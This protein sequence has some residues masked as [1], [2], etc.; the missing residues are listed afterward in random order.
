MYQ[1]PEKLITLATLWP[2]A[3]R[4]RTSTRS[5]SGSQ[6]TAVIMG[7]AVSIVRSLPAAVGI[8]T[9]RPARVA[10]ASSHPGRVPAA[11][12]NPDV[13]ETTR[14]SSGG[15]RRCGRAPART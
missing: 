15:R 10:S 1:P 6:R 4:A 8:A 2:C 3:S 13:P 14:P 9:T 11:S 12:H 7:K 5:P